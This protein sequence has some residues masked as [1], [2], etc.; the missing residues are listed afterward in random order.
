MSL[1]R[2]LLNVSEAQAGMSVVQSGVQDRCAC[3]QTNLRVRSSLLDE[4]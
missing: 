4:I 1:I 2:G 3:D